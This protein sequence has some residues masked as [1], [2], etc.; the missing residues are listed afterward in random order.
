MYIDGFIL[1]QTGS[2]I[3]ALLLKII[4][5]FKGST[6]E[7]ELKASEDV[8]VGTHKLT[9]KSD[10]INLEQYRN[11]GDRL[12]TLKAVFL[13]GNKLTHH[14]TIYDVDGEIISHNGYFHIFCCEHDGEYSGDTKGYRY[15]VYDDSLA[16]AKEYDN[17]NGSVAPDVI[18][19]AFGEAN[20]TATYSGL[21]SAQD[22][23]DLNKAKEDIA[24]NS[25]NIRKNSDNI[26]A[27]KGNIEANAK[28]IATI[29]TDLATKT[30]QINLRD[31]GSGK[32][33]PTFNAV[34][35]DANHLTHHRS[36]YDETGS[37]NG[38]RGFFYVFCATHDQEVEQDMIGCKYF[39]YDNNRRFVKV[40]DTANG[41]DVPDIIRRAFGEA[42]AILA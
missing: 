19:R 37:I 22:K 16:F 20:A 2:E 41:D 1:S 36:I 18:L 40:Y 39:V 6:Y 7:G 42:F 12:P 31:Y 4:A 27:N 23:K 8:S 33:L 25:S 14:R 3:Q 15:F 30:V 24:T 11:R 28:E 38:T 17:E 5:W 21:M 35:T 9:Q 10:V 32:T 13:V 26:S 29:K 34:F